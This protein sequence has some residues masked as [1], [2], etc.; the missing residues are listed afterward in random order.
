MSNRLIL[1]VDDEQSALD[2]IREAL[3]GRGYSVLTARS[4]SEALEVLKSKTPQ[5]IMADLR[6]EP[7][8][9]FDLFQQ[10]K[11]QTRFAKTPFFFITAVNDSLAQKFGESMGV[12]AYITKPVDIDR[13]DDLISSRIPPD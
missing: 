13:L 9:G 5:V 2:L 3:E 12:D 7:M 4:G 10:I 1:F 8:S 6:M 11:K